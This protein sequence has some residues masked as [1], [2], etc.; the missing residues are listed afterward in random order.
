MSETLS[1]LQ[2]S[3]EWIAA[4]LGSLGASRVADALAKT[5]TGWGASRANC[6]AEL[7]AERL[8]GEPAKTFTSPAMQWG[9]DTEDE[10]RRAYS[11]YRDAQVVTVGLVRH[12]EIPMT[13]ASPDGY[14]GEHGLIEIKCPN[15][16]THIETLLGKP[17][18]GSYV[19]QMMWQ[20][21]CSGRLWC[22]FVSYDPRLPADLAL[23][24]SRVA[25]DNEMA[26]G[27][28]RDVRGFLREVDEKID[29]LTRLRSPQPAPAQ[30]PAAM[31]AAP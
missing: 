24:V 17:I 25:F 18:A 28:E 31:E 16:A 9:T 19:T 7:V 4:R 1:L 29:A 22:D 3:P 10:A 26:G 27:L 12:P 20:M 8:T 5:K 14:V 23:F 15:T 6:M 30:L 13:H 2:G 21:A 11:F